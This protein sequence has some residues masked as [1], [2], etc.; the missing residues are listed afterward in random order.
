MKRDEEGNLSLR[1][2]KCR[3]NL[4]RHALRAR[5]DAAH[6]IA[7]SLTLLTMTLTAAL[8]AMTMV[9]AMPVF[10]EEKTWVGSGT[11]NS[12]FDDE[13]WTPLSSPAALDDA[14]INSEGASA[15]LSS[16]FNAKS[17]T[18]GGSAP[19]LL[20]IEEF[21]SG[22]VTPSSTDDIAVFNRRDGHLTLRG[23]SGVVVLKGSYKDS[24]KELLDQPSAVVWVG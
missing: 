20:T 13:N 14:L 12:W 24:E 23:S 5:D 15:R 17:V 10:A 18:L 1:G 21:I 6:R 9:S 2:T 11:T 7:S 19:S 4:D 16:S 22:A 8:L 3:S